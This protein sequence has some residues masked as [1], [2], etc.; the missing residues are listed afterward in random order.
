MNFDKTID[1]YRPLYHYS[2]PLGL[3]GGGPDGTIYH[4]GEYH[5]FYQY[6]PYMGCTSGNA[7]WGHTVSRDLVHWEQR[8]VA[9]GPTPFS[10][11]QYLAFARSNLVKELDRSRMPPIVYD[12]ELCFSGSTVIHDGVP[13]IIYTGFFFGVQDVPIMRTRTQCI[14]TSDDGMLTWEKHPA[15]PVLEHPPAELV[16]LTEKDH[17]L[18]WEESA[19]PSDRRWV[20]HAGSDQASDD[21]PLGHTQDEYTKGEITAWHDPHVWREGDL[22]YMALGCGFLGVGGAILLY[23]SKDL[24]EWK[25]L[26]PLCVGQDPNFNRWLVPDFIPLGD[27]H[28]L[29]TMATTRCRAGKAIYMVGSYQDLRFTPELEGFV[30]AHP[31][32][33]FHCHR[34][35]LDPNG[36]RIMF[37]VL[38]E[39][40]PVANNKHGWAGVLSL[41]RVLDLDAENRL[42]MDPAREVCS[43]G[44]P[45]WMYQGQNL[46]SDSA[47]QVSDAQ[48]DC[49]EL[50]VE[51]D[52]GKAEEVGL[53]LRCSPGGEEQTLIRYTPHQG[54][55][56]ID[57][58]RSSLDS[59]TGRS[60]NGTPLA[61]Q[62]AEPLRLHVFLDRSTVEAFANRRACLSNRTYPTRED[63]IGVE[64]FARGGSASV[65]TLKVWRKKPIFYSN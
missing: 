13:T 64:L 30:D 25:Y 54:S 49:L 59:D 24:I 5:V 19:V 34:T 11:E 50:V 44:E 36:R 42:L 17:P 8:R 3:W 58:T 43:T 51:I 18:A 2:P 46:S 9:I 29:F 20:N 38:A 33:C 7:S 14:A 55:I 40:R 22:W 23:Q 26:H 47:W 65:N 60:V 10:A 6:D 62:P 37:G 12:R 15:N 45:D 28:V 56:S 63:S 52:P 32:A 31:M 48:G 53:K 16:D 41:P 61:L 57:T 4:N 1:P 27:K 21:R 39:R 35:L